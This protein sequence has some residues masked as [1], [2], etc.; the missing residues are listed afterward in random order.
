MFQKIRCTAKHFLECTAHTAPSVSLSTALNA[1]VSV[2]VL[3]NL[4]CF[5]LKI[6][7]LWDAVTVS[8]VSFLRK[9]RQYEMQFENQRRW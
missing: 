2:L 6:A 9:A 3:Q 7:S 8:F 1:G 4:T 5:I